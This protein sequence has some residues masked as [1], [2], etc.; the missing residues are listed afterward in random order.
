MQQLPQVQG[1]VAGIFLLF[2]AMKHPQNVGV[3]SSDSF[4]AI[5]V[6]TL[7][8]LDSIEH[9]RDLGFELTGDRLDRLKS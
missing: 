9:A 4:E 3:Y 1:T 5:H 8:G 2:G 7:L 6:E